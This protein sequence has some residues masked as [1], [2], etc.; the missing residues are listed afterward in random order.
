MQIC[1]LQELCT[2]TTFVIGKQESV[3]SI[4]ELSNFPHLQGKLSIL[5]LQNI[6]DPSDA[7]QANLKNKRQI[8]ELMLGWDRNPQDSRIEKDVLENLQ[9][10][11]NLK[12]LKI[13][14]YGG[15]SFPNWVG[16]SSFSNIVML[17]IGDCNYCLSLSPFGQLPSIKELFIVRMGMVKTI[18][19]EFYYSERT[20]TSFQPFPSL[21]R[22]EFE[23]MEEWQEWLP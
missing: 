10:S 8:D 5:Q 2:L 17:K 20:L 13:E 14:H 15:T 16:G 18:G 22:L 6:V 21:E 23:G 3:L 4:R 12:K 7:I 1:K 19:H 11:I 9:P